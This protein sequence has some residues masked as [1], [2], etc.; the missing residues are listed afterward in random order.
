[1]ITNSRG[2]IKDKFIG[3]CRC[4]VVVVIWT[5]GTATSCFATHVSWTSSVFFLRN[6]HFSFLVTV[7]FLVS[8]SSCTSTSALEVIS[9]DVSLSTISLVLISLD[10]VSSEL[11]DSKDEKSTAGNIDDVS[12]SSVVSSSIFW[13][14]PSTLALASSSAIATAFA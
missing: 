14:I 5:S 11:S 6:H 7:S 9:V 10:N 12:V 4:R 1:M 2:T 13:L 3:F 8:S